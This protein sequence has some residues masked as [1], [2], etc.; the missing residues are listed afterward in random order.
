MYLLD[1]PLRPYAWGSKTAIAGL[2][3]RTPSGGPEAELWLGA[4]PDSP[5]HTALRDGSTEGLDSLIAS[6]PE[7]M[8]GS[9]VSSEFGGR[10]P[11][12]MKVLA[13]AAPLS[14]QVHPSLDQARAGFAAENHT[15]V[16]MDAA[17]RNYRDSNHKPEMIFALSDFEALCGFRP[18]SETAAV[19]RF[20]AGTVDDPVFL[21]GV[22]GLIGSGAPEDGLRAAFEQVM[23]ADGAADA[24]RA[25][26]QAAAG[27]AADG[28]FA[29]DLQTVNELSEHYPGDPGVLVALML[30]RVSLA[31]GEALCLPAGQLHA[32]LS[33]LGIEVMA[34]SD[35]VLR[36][37]LTPKHVDVPELMRI[38]SFSPTPPPLV[39]AQGTD[40]GQELYR[41]PFT[42]FQLQ[43]I[44]LQPDGGPVAL[45]QHGPVIV[46]AVEGGT[47]LD[48]PKSELGLLHG[49]SAF[50]PVTE[51][52]VLAHPMA[53]S[54]SRAVLFA[55]TASGNPLE[56]GDAAFGDASLNR[57]AG[58]A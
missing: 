7:R 21:R 58:A 33:G 5:S 17:N 28:P 53:N 13:A 4:H 34:S 48:S 44:E 46:L 49:Q 23:T 37:G 10:L 18:A 9:A 27:S 8:L 45:A 12:L 40:A 25:V 57:P 2:L 14:L 22:A 39:A 16:A 38:C 35:N 11:Y 19:F 1:N 29:R 54:T 43:R 6:D 47:R 3:G 41:P 55:V 24:V 20:L 42:E 31:A 50:I 32:Y 56:F 52:P 30:N 51:E 26:Q 36:G 15:G